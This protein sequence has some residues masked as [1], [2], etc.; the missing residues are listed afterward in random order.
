LGGW[1]DFGCQATAEAVIDGGE[2]G[3]WSIC[4]GN[5]FNGT[6]RNVRGNNLISGG[7][8]AA[9]SQPPGCITGTA[10]NIWSSTG[11]SLGAGP[12]GSAWEPNHS[13]AC[14]SVVQPTVPNGYR[15]QQMFDA[16]GTSLGTEPN[17]KLYVGH[18]VADGNCQ[19][20][21]IANTGTIDRAVLPSMLYPIV[22]KGMTL[23]NCDI[24]TTGTDQSCVYLMDSNT[25]IYRGNFIANG[26]GKCV[27]AGT[28]RNVAIT[29]SYLPQGLDPNVTNLEPNACNS[30]F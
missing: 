16:P 24:T 4:P 20:M 11:N 22:S 14:A 15:Y 10:Q 25:K 6:V 3:T 13:Y 29:Q 1:T 9:I 26:T 17:W 19:W 7:Y 18:V 8:D 2:W 5:V 12:V 28:A 30:G 27:T 21:C 23:K